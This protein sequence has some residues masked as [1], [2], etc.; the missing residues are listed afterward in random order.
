MNDASGVG[1]VN[2]GV[3]AKKSPFYSR[4]TGFGY[5]PAGAL[6]AVFWYN[7]VH[8]KAVL[9][10]HDE[11]FRQGQALSQVYTQPGSKWDNLLSGGG[12]GPG[13]PDPTTGYNS[14]VT[15]SL[16][17]RYDH[18]SRGRLMLLAPWA[19]RAAANAVARHR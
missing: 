9:H 5:A 6:D 17:F 12:F 7:G 4:N 13:A 14:I 8:G 1:D 3:P 11:P 15:P 19:E 16:N 2:V 18:G 10:F